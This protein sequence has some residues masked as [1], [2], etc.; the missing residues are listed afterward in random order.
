MLD[1]FSKLTLEVILSTAFGLEAEVQ[2]GKDN[3]LLTEGKKFFSTPQII[4]QISR[5][6]FGP[7]LLRFLAMLRQQ[8]PEYFQEVA[9][10]ILKARRQQGFSG[11]KDLLDLMMH[12]TD[13]TTTQGVSRLSDEEVVAQSVVFLLAG[14]ETSSNT[15]AFTL[16]YLVVNPEM[17]EELRTQIREALETN[18]KKGCLYDI[19]KNID[20]LD[21][22]IK[23]SQRLCPP[24]VH[25][26]R[27]CHEDFD[28]SGIHIPAGSEVVIPIYALHHDSDAWEDPEKFDPERFRGA[29]KDTNHP[30]QFLPFGGGPR[31]CIGM[32]FALLEIKIALVKIL[33]KYKF[34]RSAKTQ[35]PLMLHAGGALSAK[36]GVLVRVESLL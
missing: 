22:V 30:F 12:A 1:W 14:Y 13:E 21:C 8:R 4:R 19:V 32:R 25:V 11:R 18:A 5:L 31:N 3:E 15:L 23:E 27:E 24:A 29:R 26:N 17:Q 35:V 28:L 16:Y 34:V 9:T 33:S 20:Y 10:E 6:P 7:A 2:N 36:G